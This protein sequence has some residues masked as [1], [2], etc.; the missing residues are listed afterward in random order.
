MKRILIL[1]LLF[2]VCFLG[3]LVLRNYGVIG[4]EQKGALTTNFKPEVYELQENSVV[5][6]DKMSVLQRLDAERTY[7]INSIIPSVVCISSEGLQRQAVDRNGRTELTAV[8]DIG[9]GVVVSHQGHIVTNNHVIAGKEHFMVSMH[10]GM[11]MEARLIGTDPTLDIAVLKVDAEDI[12]LQ[13]LKF[14]NSDDVRVGQMVFA[15]GN[16]FGLGETVTQGIVSAKER[17]FSDEQRDLFQ[18][19]A[20][21]NP[22]NSGGPLVNTQG[23]VIGI[24]VSIYSAEE[25]KVNSQGV[26]FSL[27]ANEVLRSFQQIAEKGRPVRAY[28]GVELGNLT[29]EAKTF[30][31]YRG[32]GVTVAGVSKGSPADKAGLLP[33][34]VI[35]SYDGEKTEG[36]QQLIHSILRSQVGQEVEMTVLRDG[37]KIQLKAD[38][39]DVEPRLGSW[40]LRLQVQV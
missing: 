33:K 13:P 14:G 30:L 10:D 8:R 37:E 29:P 23:E 7:M 2:L 22:G 1:V 32:S 16:P 15:V 11:E 34:D 35:L 9:S 4:G 21:I 3:T 36:T 31:G 25:G 39:N 38:R 27:P 5:D 24:N 20:A 28:L 26:G 6:L 19:D 12:E 40:F 17:S 18:T